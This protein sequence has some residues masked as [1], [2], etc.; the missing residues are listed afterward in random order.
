VKQ[1]ERQPSPN[2]GNRHIIIM[3]LQG[4]LVALLSFK[5]DRGAKKTIIYLGYLLK[6][7]DGRFFLCKKIQGGKK[8]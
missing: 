2:A 4:T 7:L 3:G 5:R 8:L 1:P 6:R